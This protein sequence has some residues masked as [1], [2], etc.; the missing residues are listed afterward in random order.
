M[1]MT[2]DDRFKAI[3][4]RLTTIEEADAI[5]RDKVIISWLQEHAWN[6]WS[7]YRYEYRHGCVYKEEK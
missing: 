7:Q 6:W 5:E 1:K 4:Q 3:E 2:I